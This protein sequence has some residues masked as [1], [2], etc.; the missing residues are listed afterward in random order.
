MDLWQLLISLVIG[1][2]AGVVGGLA[3][4]GGSI[5]MIPALA[6]VFGFSGPERNEQHLYMAAAMLVNVVVAYFSSRQHAKAGAVRKDIVRVMMP[7]MAVT[8]LGGV[9]I[10][11]LFVGQ[12]PK[13]GLVVF[14]LGYC[15]VNIISALRKREEPNPEQQRGGKALLASIAAITGVVAGFLG[16]GGGIVMVPMLQIFARVPLRQAIASSTA[17]MWVTAIIGS[18]FKISTLGTHGQ[19]WSTALMLA[20]PMGLG[21]I[22]GAKLGAKLTHSM[23]LP[24]LKVVISVLLAIAAVR[25]AMGGVRSTPPETADP[26]PLEAQP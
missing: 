14:L 12:I 13:I 5:I 1:L 9:A 3:G 18:A 15:T 4:I 24:S 20:A 23:K 21:A 6:L 19:D 11:N 25:M 7:V 22:Y 17:I 8:I 2:A 16:I 10:S 26:T